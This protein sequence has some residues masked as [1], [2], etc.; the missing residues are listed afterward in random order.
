[1]RAVTALRVTGAWWV[2]PLIFLGTSVL[3]SSVTPFLSGYPASDLASTSLALGLVAPVAGALVAHAFR[4]FPKFM[5]S[6]PAVRSGLRVVLRQWW[7]LLLGI[8]AAACLGLLVAARAVPD[9]ASSWSLLLLAFLTLLGFA[10][11]GLLASWGLPVVIS[12][13][14]VAA[15]GFGW[16]SWTPSTDNVWLHNMNATFPA[17]CSDDTRPARI[18]LAA[19]TCVA[20]VLV[21][22]ALAL[23]GTRRWARL[24]RVA[25]AAALV[26]ALAAA[27]AV[28]IAVASR[29][30]HLT[31][32]AVEE[33]TTALTCKRSS[34]T[35]VC[36]W[37]EAKE[38]AAAVGERVKKLDDALRERGFPAVG[39]VTQGGRD[40]RA[41]SVQAADDLT[42]A[43]LTY[44]LAA[45]YVDRAVGCLGA[46][47]ES[48]DAR[49]AFVALLGGLRTA[50]LD[51]VL[52]PQQV[53]EGHR[54]VAMTPAG[55]R[56]WFEDGLTDVPCPGAS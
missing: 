47:G 17:C 22:V 29:S 45:G 54:A 18:A 14:L 2:L 38:R 30:H 48:R 53:V 46:V 34:G 5:R 21:L 32:Q 24:P 36:L 42:D 37:P 7:P 33:R 15:V 4:G 3:G 6:Q 10:S 9:D 52:P 28:G 23:L 44:S 8:P 43:D 31:L 55:A 26:M 27:P 12:V 16:L 25:V 19:G 40:H 13:P 51:G 11:M 41:V 35:D 49:V 50:D 20:L 56:R 39:A 1:M